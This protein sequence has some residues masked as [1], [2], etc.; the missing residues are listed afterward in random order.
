[1]DNNNA[2][3]DSLLLPMFRVFVPNMV[4]ITECGE[5]EEQITDFSTDIIDC[6]D[7]I[8]VYSRPT[9]PQRHAEF[10]FHVGICL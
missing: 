6:L 1:M 4:I 5:N 9:K 10:Y 7:G 8:L 3:T 2:D